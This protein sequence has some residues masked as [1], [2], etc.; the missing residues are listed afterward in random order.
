MPFQSSI[1][2]KGNRYA[3]SYRRESAK[4]SS[5]PRSPRRAIATRISSEVRRLRCSNPR[6]PR[7]AIATRRSQQLH[8]PAPNLFQSSIAPKGNRY[9]SSLEV[10]ERVNA[11][12]Q[13]SIAPK[14]NRYLL[15]TLSICID[16]V[17]V[18]ILDRPEGQSLRKSSVSWFPHFVP[19]LDRPEGQSL[20]C[21]PT[22]SQVARSSNPRSPRR[23]IATSTL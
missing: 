19:I 6:S 15:T 3:G 21:C 22:V 7:R 1:A 18:P 9:L 12:F 8:Y 11:G 10:F 14:G 2:P 4:C 13:S 16:R 20:R 23:A 17:V 5:N